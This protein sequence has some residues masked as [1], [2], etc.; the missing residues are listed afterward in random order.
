MWILL[1]IIIAFV[2]FC[3]GSLKQAE[4]KSKRKSI[5]KPVLLQV[6]STIVLTIATC[7]GCDRCTRESPNASK[8]F[9]EWTGEPRN[10]TPF[11]Y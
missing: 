10:K 2:A 5:I 4:N 9:N 3:V 6:I 11:G 7:V 8:D 1:I